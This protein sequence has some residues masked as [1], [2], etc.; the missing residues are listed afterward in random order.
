M[1]R[2]RPDPRA[3]IVDGDD[4]MSYDVVYRIDL[5][6]SMREYFVEIYGNPDLFFD[7]EKSSDATLN[8]WLSRHVAFY[9]E[10]CRLVNE[11]IVRGYLFDQEEIDKLKSYHLKKS[12][13]ISTILMTRADDR[14]KGTGAEAPALMKM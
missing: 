3:G 11:C 5:L 4:P 8:E 7:L 1:A 2:K 13:V 12:Q 14:A 6:K 10:S 9:N